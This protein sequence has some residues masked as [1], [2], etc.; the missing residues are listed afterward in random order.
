MLQKSNVYGTPFVTATNA[1]DANL[2]RRSAH[3]NLFALVNSNAMKV[4]VLGYKPPVWRILLYTGFGVISGALAV[5]GF[6]VIFTAL[7][8]KD[9]PAPKAE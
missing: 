5:W 3:N 2:L 7:R 1:K 6:F 8:K 9:D 4:D